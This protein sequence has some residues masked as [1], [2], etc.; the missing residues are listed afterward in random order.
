MSTAF[1]LFDFIFVAICFIF[2]LT[3][4]FRGFVKESFSLLNWGVAFVASHLLSPFVS[5]FFVSGSISSAITDIAVRSVIFVTVFFICMLSTGGL[6]KELK[7]KV[8]RPID[9]SLGVLFGLTKS[10]LIFGIAYSVII[11]SMSLLLDKRI[12]KNS[13]EF[14]RFLSEAKFHDLVEASSDVMS[15]PVQGF[16]NGMSDSIGGSKF[17]A[18]ELLD[19]KIEDALQNKI[20]DIDSESLDTIDLDNLEELD[21]LNGYDKKDIEKMNRLIEILE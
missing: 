11:S 13:K 2:V 5:K 10:L 12:D 6:L 15:A 14:P 3:A 8:P 17:N 18:Q 4:F 19:K 7:K 21:E 1:N 16:I 9:R 20:K